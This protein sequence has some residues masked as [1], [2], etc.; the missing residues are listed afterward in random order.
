MRSRSGGGTHTGDDTVEPRS[1]ETEAVLAGGE[2]T[3]V[4]CSLGDDVVVELEDDPAL[5]GAVDGDIE[6][7]KDQR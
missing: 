7:T 4:L 6:L 2:L 5:G 1:S 3:E